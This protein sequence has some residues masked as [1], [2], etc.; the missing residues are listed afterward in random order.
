LTWAR[1]NWVDAP[2]RMALEP[3]ASSTKHKEGVSE[4]HL[5]VFVK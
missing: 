3:S 2:V 5:L 1:G 4:L